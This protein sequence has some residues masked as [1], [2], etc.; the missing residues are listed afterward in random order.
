[1]EAMADIFLSYAKEDRDVARRLSRRLIQAGWTVW[2]DRR[3][4]AGRT[5]RQMLESALREMRCMVVL[6]S[7]HSIESDWVKE[8]AEEARLR[9]KLVPVLIEAVIPP[10]GFR[11]IQ[12]ADLTDWDGV[13]ESRGVRQLIA[14]LEL[15]LGKSAPRAEITPGARLAPGRNAN[16]TRTEV[17]MSGV[18]TAGRRAERPPST[19]HDESKNSALRWKIVAASG[20][21]LALALGIFA[22]PRNRRP[23][24]QAVAVIETDSVPERSPAPK[25]VTLAVH[26]ERQELKADE[27]LALSLRGR[28]SDGSENEITNADD[29]SSSDA[30]VAKVD[31]QGRV[32]ALQ[33]GTA[34]I[35]ATYGGISS[36]AWTLVVKPASTL[37][38]PSWKVAVKPQ[39]RK[40]LEYAPRKAPAEAVVTKTPE[41]QPAAPQFSPEQLRAKIASYINRAK[42]LR[43]Q[44]DYGA[45]MA[46]LAA[47]RAVDPASP[48]V[49]AEIEQTKRACIAEKKLGNRGL[50]CSR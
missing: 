33:S 25:V 28:F 48:E 12:A 16:Q 34:K 23:A 15:I 6:W 50:D 24:K 18:E 7:S 39:P 4:P 14:D 17:S 36:S 19:S 49:R 37:K 13:G 45:A 30:R 8:E 22:L 47:A 2:W 46:A 9:K 10:V 21:A 40:S 42:D 41:A 20:V 5:W 31:S 27:T 1:L 38:E 26:A 29:W 44:G 3:I 43:V 11:T 32:T 35:T